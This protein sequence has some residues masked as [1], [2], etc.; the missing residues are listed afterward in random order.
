MSR[1]K[2]IQHHAAESFGACD[3]VGH[4][5]RNHR[6][7][8]EMTEARAHMYSRAQCFLNGFLHYGHVFLISLLFTRDFS[9][10]RWLFIELQ[11]WVAPSKLLSNV[12]DF[13]N[14]TF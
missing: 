14:G 7:T 4:A 12:P 2:L 3:P 10:P 1:L 13:G 6:V 11:N 9:F 5:C 8:S